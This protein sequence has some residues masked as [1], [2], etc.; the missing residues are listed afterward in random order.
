M[1]TVA[2]KLLTAEE[3]ALMPDPGYPTELV[4]G[5]I[6]E[7]PPPKPQHGRI[8]LRV[9][10]LLDRYLEGDDRGLAFGNDT[11]VITE[12]GPDSLRGADVSF[13]SYERVPRG[14][15]L[16]DY[17]EVA[18]ELVFEV[19]SPSDR[20]PKVLGKVAEYLEAGVMLVCVLDPG[21]KEAHLYRPDRRVEIL[22]PDDEWS[23]PELLGEFRVPVRRF[24]E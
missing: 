10:S 15:S 9:G 3:F 4:R 17:F 22:S 20:W 16:E 23:A 19:L 11:G 7:M 8:C 14:S 21:S 18:P 24:F 13:Y 6:V 12:R 2:E 5:R 1:A